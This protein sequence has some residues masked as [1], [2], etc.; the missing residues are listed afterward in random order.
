M[1]NLTKSTLN[2]VLYLVRF[3]V[4]CALRRRYGIRFDLNFTKIDV[5][6][7]SRTRISHAIPCRFCENQRRGPGFFRLFEVDFAGIYVDFASVSTSILV[8][9]TSIVLRES[10]STSNRGQSTSSPVRVVLVVFR[11]ALG[12]PNFV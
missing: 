10:G 8:E 7:V 1:L 11:G 2:R 3:N 4:D 5:D 9:L 12:V 6:C